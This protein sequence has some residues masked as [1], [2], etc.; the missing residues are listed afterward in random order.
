MTIQHWI[1]FYEIPWWRQKTLSLLLTRLFS[2][3]N[4]AESVTEILNEISL[5]PFITENNI[6]GQTQ[7][8]PWAATHLVTD[9]RYYYNK[10]T[11]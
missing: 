5:P 10:H 3:R 6:V 8:T 2:E 9:K 7:I 4:L 11:R 1:L